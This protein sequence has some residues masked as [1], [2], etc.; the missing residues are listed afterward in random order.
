MRRPADMFL[1]DIRTEHLQRRKHRRGTFA[2]DSRKP[3]DPF[4]DPRHRSGVLS[5]LQQEESQAEQRMVHEMRDPSVRQQK[6]F[7]Y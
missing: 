3:R 1:Q 2:G 5:H 4:R 7:N 6:D